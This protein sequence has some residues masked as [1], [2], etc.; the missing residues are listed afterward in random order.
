MR[1]LMRIHAHHHHTHAHMHA[2]MQHTH[3]NR[4]SHMHT[5]ASHTSSSSSHTQKYP[6]PHPHP[7]T[8]PP[9]HTNVR[10]QYASSQTHRRATPVH[11]LDCVHH[12]LAG[13]TGRRR[14]LHSARRQT[15]VLSAR[16][17]P[18][19]AVRVQGRLSRTGKFI[20]PGLNDTGSS[21]TVLQGPSC[22]SAT[23]SHTRTRL[24]WEYASKIVC[25]ALAVAGVNRRPFGLLP[26]LLQEACNR[27]RH[28]S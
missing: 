1:Y 4:Y 3:E 20:I 17:Q 16:G 22:V 23:H 14:Q 19:D 7:P 11:R 25:G 26:A 15:T 24:K 2:G 6:H 5:C 18:L 13:V 8:H 21:E 10:T 9:T 28:T 12:A 27:A